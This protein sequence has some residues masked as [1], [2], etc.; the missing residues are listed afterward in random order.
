M[1]HHLLRIRFTC[2]CLFLK[3]C[4]ALRL[5]YLFVVSIYSE[6]VR[7]LD[8]LLNMIMAATAN[9]NHTAAEKQNLNSCADNLFLYKTVTGM[10]CAL[11]QSSP[12]Y[13]AV[14]VV[15]FL[16]AKTVG[17]PREIN[18]WLS[19]SN[20]VQLDQFTFGDEDA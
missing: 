18:E 9:I 14:D 10:Y 12:L 16:L 6:I 15:C 7:L 20:D 13:C 17:D 2:S 8:W 4:F 1:D 19:M 3:L 11:Y 5:L